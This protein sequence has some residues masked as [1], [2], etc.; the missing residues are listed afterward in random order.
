MKRLH[1]NGNFPEVY[2]CT[3][4]VTSDSLGPHRRAHHASQSIE[5]SRQDCWSELLQ[6]I[7]LTQG[8]NTH[9]LHLLHWQVNSLLPHHL[10]SISCIRDIIY[11]L[12]TN[13]YTTA[14]DAMLMKTSQY[15]FDII[16]SKLWSL[17]NSIPKDLLEHTQP[18]TN[19]LVSAKQTRTWDDHYQGSAAF[20]TGYSAS[21]N[22]Y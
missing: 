3:C 22:N 11:I 19:L 1:I 6:G 8:M 4:S 12:H 21:Y 16:H 5:F 17:H 15:Q 20:T 9:L 13:I 18:P 10:G 2:M 14:L 7:F